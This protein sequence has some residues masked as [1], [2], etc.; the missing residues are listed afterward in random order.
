MGRSSIVHA[1]LKLLKITCAICLL[2]VCQTT[3]AE[4]KILTLEKLRELLDQ[5]S[6]EDTKTLEAIRDKVKTGNQNGF[7]PTYN[8]AENSY[9]YDVLEKFSEKFK[10]ITHVEYNAES[11]PTVIETVN[12]LSPEASEALQFIPRENTPFRQYIGKRFFGKKSAS[13]LDKI[14]K[15]LTAEQL[16]A[17]GITDTEK[18]L[19]E[20]ASVREIT[21]DLILESDFFDDARRN[22]GRL[23]FSNREELE[24]TID[25][26]VKK[27]L[28]FF[29]SKYNNGDIRINVTTEIYQYSST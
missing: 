15:E 9:S 11:E 5:K 26:Y 10:G 23:W 21:F 8:E 4:L 17:R 3:K 12:G 20:G 24:K 22:K 27:A 2:C 16:K 7:A 6:A 14:S 29:F 25:V 18:D 1:L 28:F 19:L 13:C